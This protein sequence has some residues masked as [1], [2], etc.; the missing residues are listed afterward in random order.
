MQLHIPLVLKW[1]MAC[2]SGTI[3]TVHELGTSVIVVTGNARTCYCE[4]RP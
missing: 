1:D 2:I 3:S 4:T